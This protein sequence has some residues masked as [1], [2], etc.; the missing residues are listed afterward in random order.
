VR[1]ALL[2]PGGCQVRVGASHSLDKASAAAV[3]LRRHVSTVS[4]QISLW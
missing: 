4:P 3:N 2:I 1:I